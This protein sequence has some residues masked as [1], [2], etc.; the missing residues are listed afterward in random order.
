MSRH[1]AMQIQEP[2]RI[3]IDSFNPAFANAHHSRGKE[4]LTLLVRHF[5]T[6]I[7]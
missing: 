7:R 5:V 3:P 1:A 4:K 6:K 2:I